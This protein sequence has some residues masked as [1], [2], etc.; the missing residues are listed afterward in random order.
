MGKLLSVT[1]AN[2]CKF[3]AMYPDNSRFKFALTDKSC[4][5][6]NDIPRAILPDFFKPFVAINS[7]GSTVGA[8]KNKSRF[9]L[10]TR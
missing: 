8:I 9:P 3:G 6:P 10:L 1:A 7:I 2:N 5:F 4:L